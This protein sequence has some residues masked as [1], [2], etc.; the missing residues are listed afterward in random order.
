MV[1]KPIKMDDLGGKKPLFLVQHLFSYENP[2][3]RVESFW[4]GRDGVTGKPYPGPWNEQRVETPENGWLEDVFLGPGL[5]F[6]GEHVSFREGN[7]FNSL[8]HDFWDLLDVLRWKFW[9]KTHHEVKKNNPDIW[10][11]CDYRPEKAY[12][13]RKVIVSFVAKWQQKI[14]KMI[15]QLGKSI[16]SSSFA[17]VQFTQTCVLLK[18][19]LNGWQL[20]KQEMNRIESKPTS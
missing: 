8:K 3:S 10:C 16:Y 12:L 19:L 18:L 4:G 11:D 2:R 17:V 15:K 1:P 9:F 13:S 7:N 20:A 6:R 5:V 14:G